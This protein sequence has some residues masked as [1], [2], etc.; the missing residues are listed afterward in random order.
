MK[1]ILLVQNVVSGIVLLILSVEDILS[2]GLSGILLFIW[3]VFEGVTCVYIDSFHSF[4]WRLIP[5]SAVLLLGFLTKEKI[6]YGDGLVMLSIGEWL[7]MIPALTVF[8]IGIIGCGT[9][10]V[11]IILFHKLNRKSIDLNINIP[12]VPFILFGWVVCGYAM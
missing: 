2:K 8:S 12:F 10:A 11:I 9:V 7:G 3:I 5:G 4:I 1:D 6:G